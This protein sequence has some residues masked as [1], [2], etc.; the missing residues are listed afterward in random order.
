MV[1]PVFYEN[2]AECPNL[3]KNPKNRF[4]KN[5]DFLTFLSKI[6]DFTGF[7]QKMRPTIKIYAKN[8]PFLKKKVG[9]FDRF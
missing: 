3:A 5:H 4:S 2:Q 8:G 6:W 1:V 7:S 9:H